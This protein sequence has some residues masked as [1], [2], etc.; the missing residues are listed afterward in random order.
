VVPEEVTMKK[1]F[2]FFLQ[3]LFGATMRKRPFIGF[4]FLMQTWITVM[5]APWALG[6]RVVAAKTA[7]RATARIARARSV[8]L[9]KNVKFSCAARGLEGKAGRREADIC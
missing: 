1:R 3:A 7:R 2:S 8:V 5:E 6:A 9:T 4:V